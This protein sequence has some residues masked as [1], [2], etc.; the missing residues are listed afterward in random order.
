MFHLIF[1]V[2]TTNPLGLQGLPPL[3]NNQC[4]FYKLLST[5]YLWLVSLNPSPNLVALECLG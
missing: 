5:C 3:E 1:Y 4:D 2:T